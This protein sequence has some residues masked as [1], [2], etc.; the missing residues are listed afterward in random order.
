MS[1]VS[2]TDP[3]AEARVEQIMSERITR[4][5]EA[6][7]DALG[8]AGW[9][10]NSEDELDEALLTL[11]GHSSCTVEAVTVP[12]ENPSVSDLGEVIWRT[13]R[14]DEST[15]SVTG[16][17]IV[18]RAILARFRLPVP[19]EPNTFNEQVRAERVRQ[20]ERGFDQARDDKH[21]VDHLLRWA[22]EY[23]RRGERVKSD[24]LI[25]AARECFMRKHSA[26]PVAPE[27]EYG[28][29]ERAGRVEKIR[30]PLKLAPAGPWEE[31]PLDEVTEG[32]SQ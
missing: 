9:E 19:V 1:D 11:A 17:N 4:Y 25:E 16:A 22:Q 26:V 12:T 7:C 24:A 2:I 13:S 6:A 28:T 21:G 3:I 27:W 8:G 32:G 31:V 14:A 23:S 29:Q 15:I 5:R 10:I 30:R 20:V 18:A